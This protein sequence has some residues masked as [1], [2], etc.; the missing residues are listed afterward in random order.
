M[1]PKNLE[2]IFY[3]LPRE[4]L[5]FSESLCLVTSGVNVTQHFQKNNLPTVKH[6][7]GVL[8]WGCFDT[9]G[10]KWIAVIDETMNC[11]LLKNILSQNVC[12]SV[13]DLKIKH[14]WVLHHENEQ[15]YNKQ[16]NFL[17]SLKTLKILV[18][19]SQSPGFDLIVAMLWHDL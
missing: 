4:E 3:G 16:V 17:N 18:W 14:I 10:P 5:N 2:G 19:P 9:S 13:C 7:G 1:I 11:A 12:P 15:K 8:V 6:G